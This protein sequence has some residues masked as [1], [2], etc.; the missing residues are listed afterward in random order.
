MELSLELKFA[1]NHKAVKK[2][3]NICGV[4][5]ESLLQYML[6]LMGMHACL[7]TDMHKCMCVSMNAQTQ[8]CYAHTHTYE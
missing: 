2:Q 4:K 1:N 8:G 6:F 5:D 3:S 7:H